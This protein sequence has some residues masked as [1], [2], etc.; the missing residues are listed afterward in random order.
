MSL[1]IEEAQVAIDFYDDAD[2]FFWHH[3]VLL[4]RLDGARWVVATPK[5]D[6]ETVDLA[7]HRVV[8]I[9]RNVANFPARVADE[10]F[11]FD[12][13]IDPNDLVRIRGQARE[14]AG[15]LSVAA[16]AAP[17]VPGDSEWLFADTALVNF[18]E[19]V[20]DAVMGSQDTSVVCEAV[21][22]ARIDL[23]SE[24]TW[25]HV[26]RVLRRDLDEWR[27]EK[28]SGPGRDVRLAGFRVDAA[29]R[30]ACTIHEMVPLYKT[31]A[32][33]P[34]WPFGDSPH[35]AFELARGI[36]VGGTEVST[37]HNIWQPR[38]GVSERSAVSI[39]HSTDLMIFHLMVTYDQYDMANSAAGE[40]LARN[41][42]RIQRAVRRNPRTP[43]FSGLDGMTRQ[44]FDETGGI[45]CSEF[46]KHYA[47]SQRAQAQVMKQSRLWREEQDA[48]DK[49]RRGGDK[50][51]K[52]ER[53]KKDGK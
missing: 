37:S 22:L 39:E 44:A 1:D 16:D 50:N 38:S 53:D 33:P 9:G 48:D 26:A 4:H 42:L 52:G 12:P 6:V 46:D 18:G 41:I 27:Q 45:I 5:L 10:L 30:R 14:L 11:A 21:G 51:D 23:D 2:G 31:S 25:V 15:V 43:D 13:Q 35:A 32:R 20:P 19:K 17:A 28:Q 47:E 8:P 49:R 40:L 34:D 24:A 36:I 29:G 7:L 3:R